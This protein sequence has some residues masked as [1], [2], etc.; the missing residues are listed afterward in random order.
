MRKPV[1][2]IWQVKKSDI[3]NKNKVT[4]LDRKFWTS[5][6]VNLNKNIPMF[7]AAAVPQKFSLSAV[8]GAT[9]GVGGVGFVLMQVL[10]LAL[11]GWGI[12]HLATAMKNPQLGNQAKMLTQLI[13][14]ILVIGT[15]WEA[16]NKF[17]SLLG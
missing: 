9:F 8:T 6:I 5:A 12:N 17:F 1:I 2:I 10:L 16:L 7:A 11:V 15:I 3:K 14:F 4:P 13:A